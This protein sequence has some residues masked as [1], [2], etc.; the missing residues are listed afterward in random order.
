MISRRPLNVFFSTTFSVSAREEAVCVYCLILWTVTCPLLEDCMPRQWPS[1][2]KTLPVIIQIGLGYKSTRVMKLSLLFLF[3]QEQKKENHLY[4]E[5]FHGNQPLK[6][7]RWLVY[8]CF[9][10]QIFIQ[11]L[12]CNR[13]LLTIKWEMKPSLESDICYGMW[14]KGKG[15]HLWTYC[16]LG[17]LYWLSDFVATTTSQNGNYDLHF[18]RIRI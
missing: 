14:F 4:L 16:M 7:I 12:L 13:Y 3:Q 11:L 2:L 5:S 9:L 15:Q 8:S 10:L 17:I 18:E 6:D 1:L